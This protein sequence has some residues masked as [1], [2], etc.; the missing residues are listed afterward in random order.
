[1]QRWW[2]VLF[3][4]VLAACLGLFIVA[5]LIK[6]WWLPPYISSF[7]KDIDDLYYVILLFTGFFFVLTEALLVYVMWRYAYR[8]GE[9][10]VYVEGNHR[11]EV[12]WTVVPAAILLFI[13]VAQIRAWERIKYA[14]R[15]PV[16]DQVVQVTARQ[17]EWRFR[18]PADMERFTVAGKQM[19]EQD[20]RRW[21]ERPEIDDF[22]VPQELHTWKG[23]SLKIYLQTGDVLH[24]FFQPHAR[25]KQDALPGKTI[26]VWFKVTESNTRF[27]PLTGTCATPEGEKEWEIACAELC[28]GGHYRMRGQLYVHPTREDYEAWHKHTLKNQHSHQPTRGVAPTTG[29]SKK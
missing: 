6:G 22:Y 20:R 12:A 25:I 9:K 19:S 28:G 13:A 4:V 15:M 21:A 18:H 14:S 8:P 2:S 5:P 1:V 27:D 7:S 3:G 26:P 23:A 17:W 29:S 10:A 16:P 11:L 24:S